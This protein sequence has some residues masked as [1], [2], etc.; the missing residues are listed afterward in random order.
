MG[1]IKI[2]GGYLVEA[3][4][5]YWDKLDDKESSDYERRVLCYWVGSRYEYEKI[6]GAIEARGTGIETEER[7][8]IRQRVD[9]VVVC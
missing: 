4:M 6:P 2:V 8:I 1:E 9:L 3:C 7:W 5:A